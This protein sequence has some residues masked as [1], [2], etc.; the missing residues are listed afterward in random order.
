MAV[1]IIR[2]LQILYT[3][4]IELSLGFDKQ[5]RST[6]DEGAGCLTR[7]YYNTLLRMTQRVTNRLGRHSWRDAYSRRLS[8][9]RRRKVHPQILVDGCFIL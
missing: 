5:H 4:E 2:Y 9:M 7:G 8:D 1:D 3:T 6:S